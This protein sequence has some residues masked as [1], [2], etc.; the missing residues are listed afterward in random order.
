MKYIIVGLGVFGSSLAEKLVAQGN[1]VIGV[2]SKMQRVD[3]LKEKLTHVVC[4]NVTDAAAV[5]TLPLKNTDVVIVCIGEDQGANIMATAMFKNLNVK[6]LIG[7]SLNP[8]HENVL[9]AIG[10]NEIVRPEEETAERWAKKLTLRG[11]VDSFELNENYS[12][13]EVVVPQ[14]FV[15]KTIEEIGFRKE[16]NMLVLTVLKKIEKRSVI[17]K[18]R[19]VSDVQGIPTPDTV[20][21]E[22]DILVVY[23]S[24]RDI[25]KFIGINKS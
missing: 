21:E 7:R 13:V 9:Q 24:N 1:E 6:R 22:N 19:I 18:T 8:L 23:G 16:Y 15:G 4:L 14:I 17:G 3:Q 12:I 2:D 11:M 25:K 10:V 20:L 5:E